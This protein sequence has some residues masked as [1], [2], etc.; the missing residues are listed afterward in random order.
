MGCGVLLILCGIIIL[1][2]L[3]SST[4]EPGTPTSTSE[5]MAKG[6]EAATQAGTGP[7]KAPIVCYT[8]QAG[9][10]FKR[11]IFCVRGGVLGIEY[12]NNYMKERLK[13]G[14]SLQVSISL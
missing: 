8:I 9:L 6:T 14:K 11:S 13:K 12:I 4:T 2:F 3:A 5:G 1:G 10:S 7:S